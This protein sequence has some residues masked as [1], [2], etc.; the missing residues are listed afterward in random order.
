MKIINEPQDLIGLAL[1]NLITSLIIENEF[2]KNINKWK[3]V[4]IVEIKDLYPVTIVFNN[5]E[6]SI[7]YDERPKYHLK[8]IITL[9]AFIGIA[10]GSVGLISAFLKGQIKVKKIYRIFT[11]LKFK[12]ILF[13]A[14]KKAMA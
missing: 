7:E 2:K 4:I 11:I 5:G 12:N 9:G 10:D 3:R 6:I 13:T 1:R 14:L 8:I